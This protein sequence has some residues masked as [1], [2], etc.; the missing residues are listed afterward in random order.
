MNTNEERQPDAREAFVLWASLQ[1]GAPRDTASLIEDVATSY[2][3]VGVLSTDMHGRRVAWK[4]V[5]AGSRTRVT[6]PAEPIGTVDAWTAEPRSLRE[7]SDH[8]AICGACGGEKRVRCAVCRGTGKTICAA[9]GGQRK[10][11]GYAANGSRRLLNC[12]ACRGK[13]DVDCLPCRRGIVTC[14][15]CGGEGRVQRWLEIETWRRAAAQRHP[16]LM[17]RR[18]GW[19]DDPAD[20]DIRRD[21]S[22]Q[23]VIERLHGLT[24]ADLGTVPAPWL[25]YLAVPLQP[26]ERIARQR[27]RIGRVPQYTVHYRLDAEDDRVTFTGRRLIAPAAATP[28]P[29]SRRAARL[30]TRWL[31]LAIGVA[32]AVALAIVLAISLMPRVDQTPIGSTRGADAPASQLDTRIATMRKAADDAIARAKLESDANERLRQRLAAEALLM[33]WERATGTR[34]T[35]EL[36]ELRAAMAHDLATVENGARRRRKR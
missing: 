17:A 1:T 24:P 23:V 11:Y 14:S 19:S 6:L 25:D 36:T 7:R 22:L 34:G 31:L 30:R 21:A 20:V 35:P 5:P 4:S 12:T 16:D 15:S 8:I 3:Y 26:G 27:L 9:C 28:N 2:D 29:F 13:G 18:L 10:M 33:E 32:A